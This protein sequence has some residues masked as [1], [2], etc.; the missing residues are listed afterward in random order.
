MMLQGGNRCLNV[1]GTENQI[2]EKWA[3]AECDE[4]HIMYN[5]KPYNAIDQNKDTFW[6]STPDKK[7][8]NF[9]VSLIRPM[10]KFFKSIEI[11]WKFPA[12]KFEIWCYATE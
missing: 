11:Q 3:T 10:K 9:D 2:L 1:G 8:I 12:K 4:N 6:I 5:N 7:E